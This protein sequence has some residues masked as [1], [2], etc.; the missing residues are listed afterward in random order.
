MKKTLLTAAFSIMLATGAAVAQQ[1]VDDGEAGNS[2]MMGPFFTDDTMTEVRPAEEN[3]TT[4]Q[5]LAAADQETLRGECATIQAQGGETSNET[6]AS[7][8]PDQLPPAMAALCDQVGS[9]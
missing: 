3:Q 4:F 6:T 7:I 8:D 2:G 1:A 5:G 9:W